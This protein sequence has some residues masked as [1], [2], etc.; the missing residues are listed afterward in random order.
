MTHVRKTRSCCHTGKYVLFHIHFKTPSKK[1]KKKYNYFLNS[2]LITKCRL[3]NFRYCR[4]IVIFC[5]FIF[6]NTQRYS[7]QNSANKLQV[8][9]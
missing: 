6:N 7:S 4:L 1:K 9:L 3:F 5:I 8:S 2:A